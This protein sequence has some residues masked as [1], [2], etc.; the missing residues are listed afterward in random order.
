MLSG[1]FVSELGFSFWVC[2]HFG[3]GRFSLCLVFFNAASHLLA[4]NCIFIFYGNVLDSNLQPLSKIQGCEDA[5]EK[6]TGTNKQS[7]VCKY[8]AAKE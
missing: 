6:Q 1:N 4:C 2:F 8:I 5:C 3:L 7:R